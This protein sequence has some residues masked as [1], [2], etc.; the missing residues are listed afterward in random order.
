M[1][2]RL[3][4]NYIL[5]HQSALRATE[6]KNTRTGTYRKK[7]RLLLHIMVNIGISYENRIQNDVYDHF[8]D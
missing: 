5:M 7:Q 8:D 2:S 3:P 6:K 4:S 1:T